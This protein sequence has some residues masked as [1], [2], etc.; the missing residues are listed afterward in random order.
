[1]PTDH[2]QPRR[3]AR[4]CPRCGALG[5]L[6]LAQP[7]EPDRGIVDPTMLCPVCEVEFTATGMTYHPIAV[8]RDIEGMSHEELRKW[9]RTFVDAA[10]D[11][12]PAQE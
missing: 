1:M 11:K 2:E 8:P 10:L 6:P 4:N 3:D 5:I 9:A 12:P 7:H